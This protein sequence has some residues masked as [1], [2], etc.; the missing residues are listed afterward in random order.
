MRKFAPIGSLVARVFLGMVFAYAGYSKLMEPVENFRGIL[1]QYQIIPYALVPYLAMTFPWIELIAGVCLVL[2]YAP[3][4]VALI[5]ALMSLGF[6]IG[7][8]VSHFVLKSAPASCGCFGQ[9]GIQLS[10][11]QV[12][13]LDLV[14]TLIGFKLFLLKKHPWSLD[15]W[16]KK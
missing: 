1:A 10:I 8:G 14:N 16:L 6:L 3:R 15:A 7:L 13:A 4:A 12:M 5:L 11:E 9:R 2:G